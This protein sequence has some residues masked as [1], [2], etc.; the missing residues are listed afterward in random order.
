M[1]ETTLEPIKIEWSY[2]WGLCSE[3]AQAVILGVS[4]VIAVKIV[5]SF[6]LLLGRNRKESKS[7]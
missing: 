6:V 2:Q 7:N 5:V 3:T 4:I 1:I